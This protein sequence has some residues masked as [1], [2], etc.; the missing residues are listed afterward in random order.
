MQYGKRVLAVLLI[1][2]VTAASFGVWYHFGEK[3]EADTEERQEPDP[4][5]LA[6]YSLDTSKLSTTVFKNHVD[7]YDFIIPSDMEIDMSASQVRAVLE[8]KNIRMEIYREDFTED[9][10]FTRK[11][12]LEYSHAPIRES[13][14]YKISYE[15]TIL[16]MDKTAEILVWEREP[17]LYVED[18][19]HHYASIELSTGDDNYIYTIFVKST[20]SLIRDDG[21]NE[22]IAIVKDFYPTEQTAEPY[23]Q[24]KKN[25]I[26]DNLSGETKK[27]LEKYFGEESPLTWGIFEPQAPLDMKDLNKHETS[28]DYKFPILLY[29]TGII[30]DAEKHPRIDT[31]LSN[32]KKDGRHLELTLQTLPRATSKTNMIFDVLNGRYDTYLENYAKAIAKAELPV[33][34][35]LGNEMNG[36]WCAYSSLHTGKDTQIFIAFYKHV[37]D[38]FE[39]VGANKYALWVWNPNSESFPGFKWNHEL[40]Y[41]PGDE[42]VDIVGLTA[43]NTGTYYQGENWESFDQLYKDVYTQYTEIYEKP[44]MITEFSSSSIGGDKVAWVKDM[45]EKIKKYDKI[46]VAIWWDSCDYDKKGNIARSYFIDDPPEIASI[47][48]KELGKSRDK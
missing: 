37:Y 12:Y 35:R 45:F 31:A 48:K 3:G 27:F 13:S 40:C 8:N 14:D 18:D 6:T 11:T 42:Y 30:D 29:Y 5:E 43:Y 32:A 22:C 41:Y 16:W 38:I 26:R 28:L 46:K 20:Y 44:L 24:K 17:L 47:F 19:K 9:A 34:F 1:F 21:T 33:L 25:K 2:A 15:D 23:V 10:G 7:G 39:K 36:D 4:A